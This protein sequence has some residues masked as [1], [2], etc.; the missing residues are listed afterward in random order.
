METQQAI[1]VMKNHRIWLRDS[2]MNSLHKD[3]VIDAIN[4]VIDD[5]EDYIDNEGNARAC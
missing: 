3:Q 5:L 2:N 1:E 4:V